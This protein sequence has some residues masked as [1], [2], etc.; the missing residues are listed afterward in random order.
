PL[1]ER[2]LRLQRSRLHHDLP[3]HHRQALARAVVH[4]HVALQ[5]VVAIGHVVADH[6]VLA[7]QR[8]PLA[9]LAAGAHGGGFA[10]RGPVGDV[11]ADHRGRL[12]G[13]ADGV[14]LGLH[15]LD[16]AAADVV[17]VHAVAD[18]AAGHRAG[19]GRDLLAAAAADLV[20]DEP[21]DHRTGHGAADV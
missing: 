10:I 6:P 14:A 3:T 7:A 15:P 13:L 11:V 2:I 12:G 4:P 16:H 18:V 21:A 20:A 1:L 5:P 17:A 19:R 9:R 8:D